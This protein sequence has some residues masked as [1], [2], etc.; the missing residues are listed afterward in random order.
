MGL[1]PRNMAEERNHRLADQ[2][3]EALRTFIARKT[4]HDVSAVHFPDLVQDEH[5]VDLLAGLRHWTGYVPLDYAK[6]DRQARKRYQQELRE[7]TSERIQ[8]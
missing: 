2:A 3:K 4:G 1:R 6:A 5:L 8:E 7:E